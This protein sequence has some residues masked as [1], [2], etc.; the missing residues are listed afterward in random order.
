MTFDDLKKESFRIVAEADAEVTRL[1][2]ENEAL[3][4]RLAAEA[5][6]RGRVRVALLRDCEQ[7]FGW[8]ESEAFEQ[9]PRTALILNP[10]PAGT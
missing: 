1:R 10:A 4:G 7:M 5:E 2:A 3:K 8:T 9:M 6:E